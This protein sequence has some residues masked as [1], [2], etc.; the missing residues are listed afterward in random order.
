MSVMGHLCQGT[1]AP[2]L[3]Q[4]D[5]N[6]ES[7]GAQDFRL[8]ASGCWNILEGR[9]MEILGK[10]ERICESREK[11]KRIQRVNVTSFTRISRE[12]DSSPVWK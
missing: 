3:T 5:Y 9:Y 7:S 2:H 6:K 8:A 4:G 11:S 10:R 1:T 12:A